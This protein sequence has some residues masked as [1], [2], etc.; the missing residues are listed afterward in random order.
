MTG[1]ELDL[2][3]ILLA[4]GR[5][6]RLGGAPKP[7]FE[8]GGRTLLATAAEAVR[9]AGARRIVAVGPSSDTADGLVRTREDPAFGGPVAAT[10]AGL[11][12]LGDPRWTFLLACDLP[13]AGDAVRVL[14]DALP[15]LPSDADGVC[16]GDA[17]SRPQ[18]LIGLYA[19]AAL[20]R[21]A[22]ALPARGRDAPVRAL[23]AELAITVVTTG[24]AL[25][26]DVD[27]WHDLTRARRA[28]RTAVEE[29]P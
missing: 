18:W 22:S 24:D 7:L 21:A 5:A 2:G 9:A 27:T 16:L 8:V 6:A 25:T 14:A 4:G 12:A 10:V 28:A 15:L 11:D 20:R 23:V 13:A 1:A 17:A 3:A 19:T 26:H 29:A